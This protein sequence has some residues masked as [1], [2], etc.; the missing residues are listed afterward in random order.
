LERALGESARPGSKC[1][2][3]GA[4]QYEP[5]EVVSAWRFHSTLCGRHR[6]DRR[7]LPSSIRAASRRPQSRVGGLKR[8][9]FIAHPSQ[10]FA[11]VG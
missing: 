3:T 7:S 11:R 9:L 4:T 6:R 1:R 2:A 5:S 10:V 8:A